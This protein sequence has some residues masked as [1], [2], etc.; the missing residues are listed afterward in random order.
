MPLP[1]LHRRRAT[2]AGLALAALVTTAAAPTMLTASGPAVAADRHGRDK[3]LRIT[4]LQI[5]GT[6]N[7]YHR[8]LSEAEKQVQL[9]SGAAN[10]NLWYAH[11]GIADQLERQ[12]VRGLE[13]DLFRDPQG[14]LY[15]APLIRRLA[16][17]SP[18]HPAATAMSQPGIKVLH[19][20][21][22]DYNSTCWTFRDCLTQVKSW[23]DAH[24]DHVPIPIMVEL[25]TSDAAVVRAGGVTAPAWDAAGLDEMDAEIR[26][27]F[28]P[29]DLITP[30]DV[31]GAH[32]TLEQAV[33]EDGWPKLEGSRGK[34]F[35]LMD[36]GGAI[37]DAY[38]S[39]GRDVLQGRAAFTNS[40][41]GQPDAAFLKLN[42][43]T[44]SG[45]HQI[46][47][48]VRKGYYVRTRSDE[49]I[50][51]VSSGDTGMRDA[52]LSSGAQ[53]ISTDF[54]VA[55]MAARYGTDF[56]AELPGGVPVRCNPVT[57]TS[58]CRDDDLEEP[59]SAA[60]APNDGGF[61]FEAEDLLPALRNDAPL[62]ASGNSSGIAWSGGAHLWMS[63][64][65]AG[66]S[67]T[68]P[69]NLTGKGGRF[70]LRA[71]FTQKAEYSQVQISVD[72]KPVGGPVD[73]YAPTIRL[74]ELID[75]GTLDLRGGRHELTAT[76]VGRNAAATSYRISLD[77]V[78]LSPAR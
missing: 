50:S 73:T 52:A 57:A 10:R 49:P 7:T 24:P 11:A 14:G 53:L 30:D 26:S 6:H 75:L 40:L 33:L 43:P 22:F 68:V 56:V 38:R 27:V 63:S 5:M 4:D 46:R 54:P 47:E 72:G 3:D 59:R 71:A 69:F 19:V 65:R 31:R 55:G 25:K 36:Q 9:A 48:A 67:F 2:R 74:S 77:R 76:A 70:A 41:A 1:A 23:S 32:A 60:A 15:K 37:R 42:N 34:V 8:E 58:R 62:E 78:V 21:D 29:G 20:A 61:A 51:T 45:F 28:A 13:L 35:F 66:Q 12:A 18:E 39:G 16:G 44:S 64:T 17:L